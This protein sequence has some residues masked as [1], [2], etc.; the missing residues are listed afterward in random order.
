MSSPNFQ[1]SWGKR[2]IS[3]A[4]DNNARMF[5]RKSREKKIPIF[6]KFSSSVITALIGHRRRETEG[7]LR[8]RLLV[9]GLSY[10][11]SSVQHPFDTIYG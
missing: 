6:R 9:Q 11:T 3:P 4:L 2:Q 5:F 1:K 8:P 7:L 10:G